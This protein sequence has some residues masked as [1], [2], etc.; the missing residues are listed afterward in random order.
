MLINTKIGKIIEFNEFRTNLENA[1]LLAKDN[2]KYPLSVF[3]I[4]KLTSNVRNQLQGKKYESWDELK[5]VLDGLCQHQNYYSPIM[6]NL[7]TVKQTPNESVSLFHDRLDPLVSRIISTIPFKTVDEQKIK[8]EA[9]KELVL[10][11]FIHHSI[12]E[13]LL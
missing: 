6:E 7:S 5:P 10:T 11:R 4:S 8:I 9:I 3:I 2:Q 13:T 1:M 12:P